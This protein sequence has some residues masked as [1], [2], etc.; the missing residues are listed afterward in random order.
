M[1]RL[2]KNRINLV[3][4]DNYKLITD[5]CYSIYHFSKKKSPWAK[6]QGE[7]FRLNFITSTLVFDYGLDQLKGT[8][9]EPVVH[10]PKI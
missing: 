5:L 1:L 6:A 10:L 4:L 8:G 2:E 9:L 3:A 7:I